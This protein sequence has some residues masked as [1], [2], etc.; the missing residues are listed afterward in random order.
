MIKK[1]ENEAIKIGII[2][3]FFQRCAKFSRITHVMIISDTIIPIHINVDCLTIFWSISIPIS[4]V[5]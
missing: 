5:I 1:G 3:E 2:G 4:E